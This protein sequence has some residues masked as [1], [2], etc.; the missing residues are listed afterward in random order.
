RSYYHTVRLV[1]GVS[2]VIEGYNEYLADPLFQA[3][4]VMNHQDSLDV[5]V[6]GAITPLHCTVMA[7]KALKNVP[8]LGSFM[9]ATRA[10]FMERGN[11]EKD[12][13]TM[14]KAVEDM[15]HHHMSL[16]VYPEGT[17]SHKADRTLLPFKKGGFHVAVQAQVPIVPVVFSAYDDIFHTRGRRFHGGTVH[18]R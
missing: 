7:K 10:F 9:V 8:F 12:R 3:V 16:L 1:C 13:E 4:L 18:V 2:V 14:R 11:A 6:M 5:A 15:N 17:R